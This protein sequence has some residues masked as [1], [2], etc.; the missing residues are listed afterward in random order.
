MPNSL[1]TSWPGVRPSRWRVM[2]LTR[3]VVL[4]GVATGWPAAAQTL[5]TSGNGLLNGTYYFR[6]VAYYLADSSGN[7]SDAAVVYGN[8]TFDGSGHYTMT[9]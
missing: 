9:N 7:L 8:I 2:K 3:L 6:H 5:E 4:L 1:S